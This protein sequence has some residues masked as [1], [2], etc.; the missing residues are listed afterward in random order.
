MLSPRLA[1]TACLN[2]L[3]T[4]NADMIFHGAQGAAVAS[5][6]QKS[7][8]LKLLSVLK[9]EEYDVPEEEL[10]EYFV[11]EGLDPAT[12]HERHA[13]FLHSSGSSGIPK[14]L[15][16][17]NKRIIS[18]MQHARDV[19][20]FL[21]V[22]IFHGLGIGA[23][24]HCFYMRNTCYVFNGNMPQTHATLT[25]ALKAAQPYYVVT[26]PYAL[27][28]WAEK[29]EGIDALAEA[30]IVTAGGSRIIDE[31]GDLL[32][33]QGVH[34]GSNFGTTEVGFLFSSTW[35]PKEDKAWNY[36]EARPHVAPFIYWKPYAEDLFECV[37]LDGFSGK[38]A[39]NSMDP[40]NSYHTSDLWTP[41]PTLPNRWKFV[42]R[43]D[44][45]V[46][47]ANG[48][49]VLPLEIEGR[50]R[51]DPF[52]R[53]AVVFGIDRPVPGLL[54][55]R[56]DVA[57]NLSGEEF[58]DRVWPTIQ[59]ANRH[60]EAFAQITREVVIPLPLGT[61]IP[62]TDKM[63]VKRAQ[64][65]RDFAQVIDNVYTRLDDSLGGDLQ[66]EIP[67][68]EQWIMTTFKTSLGVTLDDRETDF[69]F[70][71]VDSLKA[72]QMRGLIA[73]TLDLGGNAKNCGAMI[74]SDCGNTMQLARFLH[75]LRTGEGDSCTKT[76][77]EEMNA[78]IEQFSVVPP[79]VPGG[80]PI[81]ERN[82]VVC[83]PF[84]PSP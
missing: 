55:T 72:I 18:L 74:V 56:A 77:T 32:V 73:R 10:G 80:A 11:R 16:Y 78:L 21:T 50:I 4:L 47:L 5:E 22:P 30:K 44:D 66:L 83:R 69:F 15:P 58:L 14:P 65:Y 37:V 62:I 19:T 27:K 29:Q 75:R 36:L 40:P 48:E 46:T 45:R 84:L 28:L 9:R 24:F 26:V 34:L 43:I 81:P 82:T 61:E 8:A 59:N 39:S 70:A 57:Q 33:E 67:E 1:A 79:H 60:S 51:K 71:G 42:G 41:H 6:C 25:K 63:S 76:A 68:L 7:R 20:H 64:V 54:L 53:E 17:S 52:I 49:K 13:A 2:L 38:A 12:E 31:V 23:F 35:R 3:S